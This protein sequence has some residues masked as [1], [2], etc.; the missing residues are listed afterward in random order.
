MDTLSLR[1]VEMLQRVQQFGLTHLMGL[2]D[3]SLGKQLF[4]T[5]AQLV[6]ELISLGTTQLSGRG[7]SQ[8][9]TA[10]KGVVRKNLLATLLALNRTARVLALDEPGVE[11]KFPQPRGLSDQAFLALA[12]AYAHDALPLKDKF[13]RHEMPA[14]FV[15]DLNTKIAAFALAITQKEAAVGSHRT[16]KVEIDRKINLGLRTVRQLE[17]VLRN[18]FQANEPILREWER[19]TRVTKRIANALEPDQGNATINP[20]PKATA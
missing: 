19:A 8:T 11:N 9:S 5:L 12:R 3:E 6:E 16:A 20:N 4:E 15:E 10:N 2:P 1:R 18:K 13:I 14:N 7:A 17:A